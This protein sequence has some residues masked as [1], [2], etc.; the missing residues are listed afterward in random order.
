[1]QN[2]AQYLLWLLPAGVCWNQWA[3]GVESSDFLA[4]AHPCAVDAPTVAQAANVASL[5]VAFERAE[6]YPAQFLVV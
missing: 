1:M 6:P 5:N 2:T 3:R 4:L